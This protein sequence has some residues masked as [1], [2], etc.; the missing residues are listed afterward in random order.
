MKSN[1]FIKSLSNLSVG[2]LIFYLT[3]QRLPLDLID[4]L[5]ILMFGLG[6]LLIGI[7]V[8][9]IVKKGV[10]KRETGMLVSLAFLPFACLT[11]ISISEKNSTISPNDIY[12]W[13]LILSLMFPLSYFLYLYFKLSYSP[14]N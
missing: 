3:K 9:K 10:S 11:W 6:L 12:F 1:L 14:K 5:T 8:E 7:M 2:F 4:I 13:L